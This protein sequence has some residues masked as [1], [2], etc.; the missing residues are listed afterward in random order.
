MIGFAFAV[1]FL[2]HFFT[3]PQAHKLDLD[4]H[5]GF[6][7]G[8]FDHLPRQFGDFDGLAH[9]QNKYLT[10]LALRAPE[11]AMVLVIVT[12][13][14]NDPRQTTANLA[15]PLVINH[16]AR[17]G[18]QVVLDSKVY[19]LQYEVFAAR[20]EARRGEVLAYIPAQIAGA[21]EEAIEPRGVGVTIQAR[22]LCMSMR[23]VEKTDSLMVTSSVLG[24][25]RSSEATRAEFMVLI[26]QSQ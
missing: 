26:R 24:S 3:R 4:V 5:L 22:H 2:E 23:G 1:E 21:I 11:D 7:A 10:A 20:G 12:V 18:R 19:P 9:V 8:Q 14:G 25:F 17:T 13:T 15:G 16:K 6:Q